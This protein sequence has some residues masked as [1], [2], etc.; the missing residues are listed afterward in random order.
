MGGRVTMKR[1]GP[2]VTA[3]VLLLGVTL[4]LAALLTTCD[5]GLNAGLEAKEEQDDPNGPTVPGTG[6][7]VDRQLAEALEV[8]WDAA[9]D[10][11]TAASE[12]EYL[13]VYSS[14]DN[15]DSVADA[16][17]NGSVAVAWS[18]A[19]LDGEITGLTY[20][21]DY[22][23]NVLVRDGS[24]RKGA[25][26]TVATATSDDGD[27]PTPGGAISVDTVDMEEI[28][29]SWPAATDP[30]GLTA[31]AD[32]EYKVVYS[33][34]AAIDTATAAQANGTVSL[35]WTTAATSHTITGLID[36]WTY[37]ITVLVRDEVEN[38]EVYAAVE[39]TTVKHGRVFVI[40]NTT[41]SI[42]RFELDGSGA[43]TIVTVDGGNLFGVAVDPVGRRVYWTDTIAG[44]ISR[45]DFNGDNVDSAILTGLT[46]PRG[47]DIDYSGT[48]RYIYWTDYTD[49]EIYRA[50]ID[51]VD[52]IGS[53]HVIL[54][55]D[56]G[57][58]GP[59]GISVDSQYGD[60]YWVEVGL[61]DR[62]RYGTRADPETAINLS[63]SPPSPAIDQPYDIAVDG[64]A[65]GEGGYGVVYWVE[66]G[67]NDYLRSV[68][69]TGGTV[70][71]RI[72]DLS[73]C[74]SLALSSGETESAVVYWVD[75]TNAKVY[76]TGT[77][78]FSSVNTADYELS[79]AA[80]A[81]PLTVAV[82]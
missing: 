9:S 40:N 38:T 44:T 23:V 56:D 19:T 5:S 68:S 50:P 54:N 57:V 69:V 79:N 46:N 3:A 35:D 71:N 59:V 4:F 31:Q 32:L 64:W 77:S 6:L 7:S 12:L 1:R 45:C 30:G 20:G 18:A 41:E 34:G 67:T 43:Q 22:Y 21:T 48:P 37:S 27:A 10:R 73:Q 52:S 66:A 17:G 82:Y 80:I 55:S 65:N 42:I 63:H 81:D 8:S 24:G 15:I 28:S 14:S 58:D 70:S 62:I 16:E 60:F 61:V 26:G 11:T 33:D 49:D 39:E 36:D 47:I 13:L 2:S 29:I 53:N 78:G 74:W 76:S 51:T 75:G 72:T 25:Y